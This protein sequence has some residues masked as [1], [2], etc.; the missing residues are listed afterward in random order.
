MIVLILGLLPFIGSLIVMDN[1]IMKKSCKSSDLQFGFKSN[2]SKTHCSFVVND[3]VE[4]YNNHNSPVFLVT[5]DA[6]KLEWSL[7]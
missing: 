6:S 4:Y 1:F 5:L 3:V 2:H 7:Q